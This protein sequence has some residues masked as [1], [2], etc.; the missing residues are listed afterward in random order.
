[1]ADLHDLNL[2]FETLGEADL[3]AVEESNSYAPTITPGFHTAIFAFEDDKFK[4]LTQQETGKQTLFV[5]AK[6]I[7]TEGDHA[8]K[9]IRFN[10]FSTRRGQ[11]KDGKVI[12]SDVDNLLF[13]LGKLQ[14]FNSLGATPAALE[15]VL[16]EAQ[17]EQATCRVAVNWRAYDKD[18]G[19]TISTSPKKGYTNKTT[20]K[21]TP[22]ELPWP[23]LGDGSYDPRPDFP[24]GNPAQ[25]RETVTRTA[26][27]KVKKTAPEA[28]GATV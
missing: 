28:V 4:V 6:F 12:P 9:T 14:Q 13:A 2:Q 27:V 17:G 10:E 22:D 20:G 24:N 1:M 23:R 8:H 15:T 26:P 25:G 18:S 3:K 19:L 7:L 21:V 11:T 16:S 5:R